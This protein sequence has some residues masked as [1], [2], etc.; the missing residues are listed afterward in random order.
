MKM[1]PM[2]CDE[3]E[4]G[5][6][7]VSFAAADRASGGEAHSHLSCVRMVT[8]PSLGG[9]G[10]AKNIFH[11]PICELRRAPAAECVSVRAH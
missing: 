8:V 1:K 10:E 11:Q 7:G 3:T 4:A 6:P 5:F 2:L 9:K